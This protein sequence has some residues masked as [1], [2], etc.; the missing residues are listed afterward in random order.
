MKSKYELFKEIIKEC[1][2]DNTYKMAWGK[3]LIELSSE[4][5]LSKEKVII[6]FG[7]IAKKYIKYYWNQIIFFDL[8]QSTNILKSPIIIKYIK[9]LINIYIENNY[10]LKEISKINF[11]KTKIKVTYQ[12]TIERIVDILKNDVSWRFKIINGKDTEIYNYTKGNNYI[13]IDTKLL[14]EIQNHSFELLNIID[15]RWILILQSING[16]PRNNKKIKLS[17]DDKI[18]ENLLNNFRE[19]LG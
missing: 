2:Y 19:L 1:N 9:E 12:Q 17:Q 10:E 16:F 5:D 18:D 11:E 6:K 13:E 3:S 7:D 8:K 4:I 15:Y 14:K